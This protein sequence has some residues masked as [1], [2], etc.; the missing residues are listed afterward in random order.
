MMHLFHFFLL[1]PTL[2]NILFRLFQFCVGID[3]YPCCDS[4]PLDHKVIRVILSIVQMG[5]ICFMWYTDI[6]ISNISTVYRFIHVHC[7][8]SVYKEMIIS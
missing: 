2:P 5:N 8:L 7:I 6:L 3:L 4:R 1:I